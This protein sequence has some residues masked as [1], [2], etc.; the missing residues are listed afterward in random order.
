MNKNKTTIINYDKVI[1]QATT[2]PNKMAAVTEKKYVDSIHF[3]AKKI[4]DNIDKKRIVLVTGP[5]ASG[6]TTTSHI[7][8]QELENRGVSSIVISMDDF[9]V[10]REL[11][12]KLPNGEYDFES[13][14]AVE[15]NLFKEC[16]DNLLTKCKSSMPVFNF[17]KG[18]REDG[19]YD[20]TISEH[21]AIIIEGIHAFNPRI[22]SK[23]MEGRFYR[24]YVCAN[25]DFVGQ[26]KTITCENLRFVRRM[27][28]DFH[29][30]GASVERTKQMWVNVRA[31]EEV[32]ILPYK[33]LADFTIDTTH[34]YEP[35]LYKLELEKL[36]V[37]DENARPY[38]QNFESNTGFTKDLISEQTVVWEF[39][40]KEE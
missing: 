5:S 22:I 23:T 33:H 32:N 25:S 7:L 6:K 28:R 38:L 24:V 9:F 2:D 11:T 12:P 13:I 37:A 21:T 27:I 30:R 31:G 26:E 3:A 34:H 36:V 39:L 16:L 4:A 15:I 10:G 40:T 29:H 17:I 18:E 20:L 8:M 19:A 35:L 14:E 1:E